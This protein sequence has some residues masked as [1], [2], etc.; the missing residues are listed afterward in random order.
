MPRLLLLLMASAT[1]LLGLGANA[2]E[3]HLNGH[4][5]SADTS[6]ESARK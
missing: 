5:N 6:Q 2:C 4:Q 1:L 3:K